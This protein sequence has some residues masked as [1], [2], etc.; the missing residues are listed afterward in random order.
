MKILFYGTPDFAVGSLK[1]LLDS[2]KNVIGVVT[3][4]DKPA[5]RGYKLQK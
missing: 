4:P 2:N 3:A 1:A 5:G